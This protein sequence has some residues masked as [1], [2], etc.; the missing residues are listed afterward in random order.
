MDTLASRRA[1]LLFAAAVLASSCRKS[2]SDGL[3]PVSPTSGGDEV[4][5][6]D[7]ATPSPGAATSPP[8]APV[9]PGED[10][11][12]EADGGEPTVS[13]D[14]TPPRDASLVCLAP[15]AMCGVDGGA[16]RCVN[17]AS[18]EMS[19]GACGK[20]C[21]SGQAC[22]GGVCV[23]AC[24]NGQTICNGACVMAATDPLN[25]GGCGKKCD[26]GVCVAG[27]CGC[28]AGKTSCGS[29]CVDLDTSR[30]NCGLCNKK[31]ADG[32]S[33]IAGACVC[34]T[35]TTLC[36]GRCVN[37]ATD[38]DN[39]GQCDNICNGHRRCEG[40]VCVADMP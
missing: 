23:V 30:D 7:A 37:T 2:N 8:P 31:C 35:G 29:M 21:A 11:A 32:L 36:S 28:A 4:G 38:K 3:D 13:I 24:R 34:P 20:A 18:D 5:A 15:L 14:A 16:A 1:T 27:V 26:T 22:V 6:R 19:C 10:A 40:G 25:C 33:C 9:R 17:L 12:P 39:C